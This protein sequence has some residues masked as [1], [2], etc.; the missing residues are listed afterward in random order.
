MSAST[1]AVP[2]G[3]R[4]PRPAPGAP[5][6]YQFPRFERSALANGMHLVVAPIT[7]LPIVTVTVLI[8]AG[9]VGDAPGRAGLAQLTAKLL[10]EGTTSTGGAALSDRFERFGAS[11]EAHADWDGAL[12]TMTTL[13]DK[14]R[15]AFLLLGEVLR[16][17]SFSQREVERLK[18]E[19]L[20]ELLQLRAEPRGL[21]D[22]Y[23][24]RFLYEPTS[25]Y[26][27]P[28]GGDE[29]SVAA[30]TRD[31]VLQFHRSRYAPPGITLIA[32]GDLTFELVE[33]LAVE[34]FGDWTGSAPSIVTSTDAPARPGRAV[35]L[36][37]KADAPQSELRLGHVGLTRTHPDY[38]PAV[39]MN[40]VL[41][42][43]F[44]SRINLNLREVH[45]YTY[46]A[47][48]YFD[49]RRQAGPWVVSTAV[50][51]DVT[52]AAAREVLIEIERLRAERISADELSLA[53]SYLDGV[54]PIRYE[55]SSAIAAALAAL[56]LYG[57]PDDWYDRYR[58]RVRAVSSDHVLQAAQRHLHPEALQ[59]VV[60]GNASAIR[61]RMEAMAFG[62][63]TVYD[64]DG[65][66]L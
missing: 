42:G 17:P 8:D 64:A 49:W 38:F 21:A 65:R 32:S 53:T 4:Q 58:D 7:K 43:L 15:P 46:G 5:R 61:D 55:T 12:L 19:R 33:S 66:P 44:S 20:A 11:V 39:I 30:I 35:H 1:A 14:L 62:P 57:L 29:A 13:S 52:D 56:V 36:V 9:A 41:G 26:A 2:L 45:G 47:H 60:V 31:D 27:R 18:E 59:M 16:E 50:Q 23:F 48:S 54:F 10:L 37:A 40:A 3:G 25:R 28:D 22:E 24:S 51:S 63:V 6:A 34:A